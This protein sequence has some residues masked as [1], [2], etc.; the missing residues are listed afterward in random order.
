[1]KQV[2]EDYAA[3]LRECVDLSTSAGR[4]HGD[5]RPSALLKEGGIWMA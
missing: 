4:M 3:Y 2:L 1:M 5:G